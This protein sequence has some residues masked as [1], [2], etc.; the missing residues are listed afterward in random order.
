MS[1]GNK[2]KYEAVTLV[3]EDLKERLEPHC[4]RIEVAGSY[5]RQCQW[6]G[7]LE[8]VA[9]PKRG[10]TDQGNLFGS[11]Q[12]NLLKHYVDKNYLTKVSGPKNIRFTH[13]GLPIDLYM[14]DRQDFGMNLFIRT[15]SSAYVA[16]MGWL[17]KERGYRS[18]N[19]ALYEREG[20]GGPY[21]FAEEKELFQFLGFDRAVP[22]VERNEDG[23]Q[24]IRR[25]V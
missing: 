7:D 19:L 2:T 21:R 4:E 24:V 8:L 20:N 1:Q 11:G 10:T 3:W 17:W 5:R 9:I 23:A 12:E 13:M 22:P 6:I 14:C 25:A 15:G 18:K 16:S